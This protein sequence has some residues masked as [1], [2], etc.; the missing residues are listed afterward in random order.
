MFFT[1]QIFETK[2]C[3]RTSE[4]KRRLTDMGFSNLLNDVKKKQSETFQRI[5][6]GETTASSQKSS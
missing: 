1:Q 3:V 4:R 5:Q 6:N 2:T